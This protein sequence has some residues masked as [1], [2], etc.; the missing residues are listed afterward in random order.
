[1]TPCPTLSVVLPNY[2]HAKYIGRALG[3]LLAQERAA[4][5][6]I[7]IDDGSKDDSLAVI[8]KFATGAPSIKVLINSKNRGVVPTLERG[9]QAARGKYIYFAASDDWVLPGFFDTA[10]RRLEVNS[11]LGLFCGDALLVDGST[12][13]VL[14]V[15]PSVRPILCGGRVSASRV[16]RLL[17]ASD[18]WILTGS[19]VLRRDCALWGGGFDERLSSFAD[20]FLVRKIILRFGFF[21]E[22]RLVS[23]W[24]VMPN[25]VSRAS[26]ADPQR[27]EYML[28]VVPR[29][30][31]ADPVFP[32]WYADAYRNRWRFATCRLALNAERIDRQFL[33]AMGSRSANE[34][35]KMER[36][37][38]LPGREFP[39]LLILMRLWRLF[40]PTS[41]TGILLTMLWRRAERIWRWG[42]FFGAQHNSAENPASSP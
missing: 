24:A 7:V 19:A 23:A 14:S 18:N 22:P 5:E 36:L 35:A 27:A 20:G 26:A 13:Q 41:L 3:T 42:R 25:S 4:D 31:A 17:R 11:D 21:F 10:L 38:A 9:L 37:L 39:R 6:I 33:L 32:Q 29:V 12:N 8:E 28:D 30:V 2:N 16:E 15:R 1:M 34:R 40:R